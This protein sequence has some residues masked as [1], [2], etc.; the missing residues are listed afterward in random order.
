MMA[1]PGKKLL[2]MGQEFGQFIEWNYKQELDWMLLDYDMHRKLKDFSR[3]L[4]RFYKRNAPMWEIDYS[5]EG[6]SWIS[7]DDS[8]N[9]VIAF[10]RMDSKGDELIVVCNFTPVTREN[11]RIG[12]PDKG[13]YRVVLNT[14]SPEFGGFGVKT[15]KTYTSK[16]IPMHSFK[17]SISLTLPGMSVLY[18]KKQGKKADNKEE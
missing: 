10:R 18:L 8:A 16:P 12:V 13:T 17:Q 1:H 9:S 15:Q 4:N 7:S 11:Y 3:T 6:F 5:W 2:F 14:D